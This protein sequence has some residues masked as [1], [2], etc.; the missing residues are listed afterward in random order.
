MHLINPKLLFL[1][2]TSKITIYK[3][4][5]TIRIILRCHSV[6]AS[7]TSFRPQSFS[8]YFGRGVPTVGIRRETINAWEV[9]LYFYFLIKNGNDRT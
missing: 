4:F 7:Y 9:F 5:S 3:S 6:S 2:S 1:P 8:S